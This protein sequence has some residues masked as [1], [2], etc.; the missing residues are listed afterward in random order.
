VPT[1]KP[2]KRKGVAR[3]KHLLYS[4]TLC[5]SN[6]HLSPTHFKFLLHIV[7]RSIA[8]E[9]CSLLDREVPVSGCEVWRSLLLSRASQ[10][11]RAIDN[12]EIA[13]MVL[14]TGTYAEI[15]WE[16]ASPSTGCFG[17]DNFCISWSIDL[18]WAKFALR[19]R[20]ERLAV[21]RDWLRK[22]VGLQRYYEQARL[23]GLKRRSNRFLE[24]SSHHQNPAPAAAS[25]GC[26]ECDVTLAS[27]RSG[28][29]AEPSSHE[30]HSNLGTLLTPLRFWYA[31]CMPYSLIFYGS[32]I[33]AQLPA[34]N[35]QTC[36]GRR[37]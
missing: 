33:S 7:K 28:S 27:G 34:L 25:S 2:L 18:H 30:L 31:M 12:K 20:C 23:E 3:R 22:R 13:V 29:R 21:G 4:P 35:R 32:S 17:R 36:L 5:S 24:P 6:Q 14:Y 1:P 8:W 19:C 16:Q 10:R 11:E 37:W 26:G 9:K 15:V